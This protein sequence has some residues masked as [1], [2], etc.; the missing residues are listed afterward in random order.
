MCYNL[1][2][3]RIGRWFTNRLR[4]LVAVIVFLLFIE[5]LAEALGMEH[6]IEP[7]SKLARFFYISETARVPLIIAFSIILSP[8]T[9][10]YKIKD[11]LFTRKCPT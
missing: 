9:L 1:G 6:A 10:G 8:I 5:S 4:T 11:R 2:M 3:K 7:K